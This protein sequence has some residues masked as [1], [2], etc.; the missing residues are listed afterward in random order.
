MFVNRLEDQG[1][2]GGAGVGMTDGAF[3]EE[4]RPPLSRD[5]RRRRVDVP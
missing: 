2:G 1:D 5:Q 3:A 4:L